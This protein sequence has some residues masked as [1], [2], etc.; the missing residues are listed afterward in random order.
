MGHP[1]TQEK[2]SQLEAKA[3]IDDG[4]LVQVARALRAGVKDI[5]G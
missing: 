4:T 5:N 1:W 3:V 2:I